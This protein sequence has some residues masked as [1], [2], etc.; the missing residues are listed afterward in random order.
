MFA[1]L[2]LIFMFFVFS[3]FDE[4][5]A[6]NDFRKLVVLNGDRLCFAVLCF[7]AFGTK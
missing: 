3:G 4:T 5:L 1:F 7:V 2:G 6:I